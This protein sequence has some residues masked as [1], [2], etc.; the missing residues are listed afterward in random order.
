MPL[1]RR[2]R[3]LVKKKKIISE[4]ELGKFKEIVDKLSIYEKRLDEIRVEDWM[5]SAKEGYNGLVVQYKAAL[6][7]IKEANERLKA[8]IDKAAI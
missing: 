1:G 3:R 4:E 5:Q 8:V 6:Q 2:R 7:L